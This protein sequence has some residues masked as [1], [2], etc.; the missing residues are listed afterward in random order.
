[1]PWR[2]AGSTDKRWRGGIEEGMNEP[3]RYHNIISSLGDWAEFIA[4]LMAG[5]FLGIIMI[6]LLVLLI[7]DW[8]RE[9]HSA[10]D[11]GE[12]VD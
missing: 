4:N 7:A 6:V 10:R 1:M 2:G 12:H 9:R 3:D 8:I 11:E 5:T